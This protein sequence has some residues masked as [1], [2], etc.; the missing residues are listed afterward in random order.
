M[1]ETWDH[2]N[3]HLAPPAVVKALAEELLAGLTQRSI[4]V[5]NEN[6]N[7]ALSLLNDCLG[8]CGDSERGLL[9]ALS[10][11]GIEVEGE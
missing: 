9:L 8:D 3:D 10:R 11:M 7:S 6:F 1:C 5:S 4:M 2:L